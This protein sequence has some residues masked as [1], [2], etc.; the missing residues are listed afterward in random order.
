MFICE[1]Y[2]L[3]FLL[4]TSFCCKT[5]MNKNTVSHFIFLTWMSRW[6]GPFICTN[7]SLFA[8]DIISEQSVTFIVLQFECISD[9][10]SWVFRG[11]V[12]YF[13]W[14]SNKKNAKKAEICHCDTLNPFPFS[15]SFLRCA[16]FSGSFS[17]SS[18]FLLLLCSS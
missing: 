15:L 3:T 17:P 14:V 2:I 12:L 1:N 10:N 6:F 5:H 13:A 8:A 16:T 7:S 18:L 9:E 11:Y 4:A